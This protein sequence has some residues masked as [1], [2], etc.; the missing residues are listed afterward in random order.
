VNEEQTHE[1]HL[2]LPEALMAE[3]Q[4]I[5]KDKRTTPV[6]LLRR[7][8]KLGLVAIKIENEPDAALIV[9]EGNDEREITFLP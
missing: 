4:Q 5:A 8:I 2:V 3:I 9:R 6:E 7:F 1:Y